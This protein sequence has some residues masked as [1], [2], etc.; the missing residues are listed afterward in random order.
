[1]IISNYHF[2]VIYEGSRII[3]EG[4]LT[5]TFIF[6]TKILVKKLPLFSN[7]PAHPAFNMRIYQ[8]N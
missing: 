6:Q 8:P 3:Y 4:E 5:V 1:M 7:Y 2:F